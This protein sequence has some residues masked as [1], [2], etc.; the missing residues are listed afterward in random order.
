MPYNK[1]N[2]FEFEYVFYTDPEAQLV[3]QEEKDIALQCVGEH[4]TTEAVYKEWNYAPHVD[5][6]IVEVDAS[7]EAIA[8]PFGYRSFEKSCEARAEIWNWFYECDQEPLR[9]ELRKVTSARTELCAKRNGCGYDITL[10]VETVE[11]VKC[12]V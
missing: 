2:K 11:I 10:E 8:E 12:G 3:L 9:M 5:Y 4:I 6:H 1:E 7:G